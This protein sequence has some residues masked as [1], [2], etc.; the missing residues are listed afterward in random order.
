MS[1]V[2]RRVF[3][4][5]T[6]RDVAEGDWL[7]QQGAQTASGERYW[8]VLTA[9]QIRPHPS[10]PLKCRWSVVCTERQGPTEAEPYIPEDFPTDRDQIHF[11]FMRP[12]PRHRWR[13]R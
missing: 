10:H 4:Y 11:M 3:R 8:L 9:R 7:V 6:D 5:D 1:L 13:Q 2:E 12:R